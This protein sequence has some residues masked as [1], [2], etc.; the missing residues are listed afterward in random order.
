MVDPYQV[1]V[2]YDSEAMI[3][4]T[5]RLYVQKYTSRMV[6]EQG[7]IRLMREFLDVNASARVMLPNGLAD[8]PPGDDSSSGK[9]PTS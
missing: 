9:G 4:A 5:G 2:E 8:I 7:K 3:K 1:F 6:V